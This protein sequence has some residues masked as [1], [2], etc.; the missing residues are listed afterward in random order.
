MRT[1]AVV[2][3]L[4]AALG[5]VAIDRSDGG[6]TATVDAMQHYYA[7]GRRDCGPRIT[8]FRPAR[9]GNIQT[10][11]GMTYVQVSLSRRGIPEKDQAALNAGCQSRISG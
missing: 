3:A 7:L 2:F 6:A 5:V 9:L 11:S 4:V 1:L 10:W 8:A